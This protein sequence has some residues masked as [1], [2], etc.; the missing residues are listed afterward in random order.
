MDRC[1]SSTHFGSPF[2]STL[3]GQLNSSKL[4]L[5]ISSNTI[6]RA[7]TEAPQVVIVTVFGIFVA[8]KN[9]PRKN[10]TYLKFRPFGILRF[11]KVTVALLLL[12][13]PIN[14]TCGEQFGTLFETIKIMLKGA[15][16]SIISLLKWS[17]ICQ[18]SLNLSHGM[19]MCENAANR[20]YDSIYGIHLLTNNPI[21]NSRN[22]LIRENW[23]IDTR[24]RTEE[25]HKY[26]LLTLT[27]I[28]C[29]WV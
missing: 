28:W 27:T 26:L 2:W 24:R 15:S 1:V 20:F 16:E 11:G 25:P 13:T 22:L 17:T 21:S 5:C 29:H 7:F 3:D 18:V 12:M 4:S 8:R 6:L 14:V 10:G 9:V 19:W 23:K